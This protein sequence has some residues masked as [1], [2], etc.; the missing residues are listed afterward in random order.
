MYLCNLD[1]FHSRGVIMM[2]LKGGLVHVRQ[3]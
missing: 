1:G 2:V 3:D